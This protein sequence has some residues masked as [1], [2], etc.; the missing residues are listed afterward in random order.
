MN[1][2]GGATADWVAAV[3][4][5]DVPPISEVAA[6]P[7]TLDALVGR[8][9]AARAEPTDVVAAALDDDTRAALAVLLPALETEARL[10]VLGRWV[11]HRFLER[12]L[13][14]RVALEAHERADPGVRDEPV[15]EPWFVVG[16]P[17]SG[18]TALYAMLAADPRLRAPTG[19]ELL[20]PVPP[21]AE[22]GDVSARI[23][24][25]D[26]ELR[27]PHLVSG[28]MDAI[29]VYAARAPK[30]CLSAMSFAFRSEEFVARYSVPTYTEWLAAADPTPAYAMHR[31]ILRVLQRGAATVPHWVLKS[32]VH[33]HA[34]PTLLATY[35]DAR[36]VITHRDPD[37]FLASVSSLV[38]TLRS[39][40][41]DHVDPVAIGRYHLDRYADSLDRL[42]D[43][44]A[45]GTVDQSR[46]VWV[47]HADLVVD[48]AAVLRRVYGHGT[49]DLPDAL[50]ATLTA[51]DQ[52]T[53]E[54]GPHRYDAATFGLDPAEVATRFA[55]ST[56]RITELAAS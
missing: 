54:A 10:S 16:P 8:V 9:A 50:L 12:L 17:R 29:H 53:A 37:A 35:P 13:A 4:R 11:T 47:R 19:W 6:T 43:Q 21:P 14:Q 3:N 40:H 22:S 38:A 51:A 27:T 33:L 42:V 48:P 28:G 23:A 25:A 18:T 55:R 1:V 15:T 44:V 20:R 39:V 46:I 24:L 56:A 5:G 45:D 41:S 36:I 30:E 31:R 49:V 34:V 32:P 26:V 52:G 2:P 7:F